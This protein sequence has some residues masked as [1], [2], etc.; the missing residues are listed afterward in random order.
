MVRWLLALMIPISIGAMSGCAL[1]AIDDDDADEEEPSE[2]Q[3]QELSI[4]NPV[5]TNC[6]DPSVMKDGTCM[7]AQ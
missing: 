1:D 6:A 5:K 7:D 2:S 4:R 3:V